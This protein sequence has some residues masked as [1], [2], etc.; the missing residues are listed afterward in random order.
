MGPEQHNEF[1][2]QYEKRLLEPFGLNGYGCCEDLTRKLDY[3]LTIPNLRRISISPWA[4]VDECAEKLKDRYIFSWKPKPMHL[5]G[6]FDPDEIRSYIRNTLEVTKSNGCV[7]EM[8][9]KD[10]HTC[11]HHPERF[12]EWTRIAREEIEEV[13]G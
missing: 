2:L 5:V 12:D 8:Y 3:V 13:H 7:L 6:E 1:I 11:E 4:D 9:L 10:T